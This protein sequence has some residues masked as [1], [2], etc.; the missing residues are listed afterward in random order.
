MRTPTA[1][2]PRSFW[3]AFAAALDTRSQPR[4]PDDATAFEHALTKARELARPTTLVIDDFHRTTSATTDVDM[5]ELLGSSPLLH[6]IIVARRVTLLDS[7]LLSGR[8]EIR[9]IGPD[10]LRYTAAEIDELLRLHG[11]SNSPEL[12]AALARTRG[13][14]LAVRAA[15]GLTHLDR[16]RS[17][18]SPKPSLASTRA[19]AAIRNLRQFALDSLQLLDSRSQQLLLAVA[20]LDSMGLRQASTHLGCSIDDA[21]TAMQQLVELG[22]VT[23]VRSAAAHVF[24][25]HPALQAPLREHALATLAAD[26]RRRLYRARGREAAGTHPLTA[27]A[28]LLAAEDYRSAEHLLARHFTTLTA[29]PEH[30]TRS[31]HS[32]PEPQLLLHPTFVAALLYLSY[33]LA[34]VPESRLSYLFNLWQRG[35]HRRLPAGVHT[36]P[37]PIHLE[38]LAQAMVMHRA[39]GH[40]QQARTI[41]GY[42]ESRLTPETRF[43][44]SQHGDAPVTTP[45]PGTPYDSYPTIYQELAATA[46]TTG[47]FRRARHILRRLQNLSREPAA[48]GAAAATEWEA[49]E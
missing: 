3:S 12:A 39:A 1:R 46:V 21:R 26:E 22:L 47:D 31:L 23:E 41:M 25:S 29:A 33:S 48:P 18:P 20:Q 6:V 2:P 43:D 35:L 37:G 45:H 15:L 30:A 16:V 40:I 19:P 10:Q 4:G 32:I 14:P 27:F 8:L 38:L 28:L 17:A 5:I 49:G 13:W 44:G 24:A 34:A 36:Q 7:P 9:H 42:V 11:F